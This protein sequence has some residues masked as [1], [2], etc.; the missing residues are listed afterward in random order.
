MKVK[1]K[2]PLKHRRVALGI[3]EEQYKKLKQGNEVE[4]PDDI[5]KKYPSAFEVEKSPKPIKDKEK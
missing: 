4:I 5:V 1:K 2:N 3:S